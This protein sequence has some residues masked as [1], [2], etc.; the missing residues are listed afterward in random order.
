MIRVDKFEYQNISIDN[1]QLL[2]SFYSLLFQVASHAL[3]SGGKSGQ[4]AAVLYLPA[5]CYST[6]SADVVS[7]SSAV[8]IYANLNIKSRK[9]LFDQSACCFHL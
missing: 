7:M 8:G 3:K 9:A 1:G 4:Q 5:G 2:D 6:E